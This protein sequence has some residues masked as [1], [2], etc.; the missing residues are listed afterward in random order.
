MR[1][2]PDRMR[3]KSPVTERTDVAW[4]PAALFDLMFFGR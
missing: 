4:S 2:M 3:I 1:T